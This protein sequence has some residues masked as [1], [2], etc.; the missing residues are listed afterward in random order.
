MRSNTNGERGSVHFFIKTPPAFAGL[1]AASRLASYVRTLTLL[2]LPFLRASRAKGRMVTAQADGRPA[3]L[4][5]GSRFLKLLT[6]VVGIP[7]PFPYS[8][9]RIA[10]DMD[11]TIDRF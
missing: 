11:Q 6:V 4:L 9:A 10:A 7:L 3:A 8:D 5:P 2:T 1:T